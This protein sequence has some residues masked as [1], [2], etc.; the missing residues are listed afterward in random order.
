MGFIIRAGL[1]TA[2]GE[3]S[4]CCFTF[5]GHEGNGVEG[6]NRNA[7]AVC[8]TFVIYYY[9]HVVCTQSMLECLPRLGLANAPE[10]SSTRLS[11]LS[12]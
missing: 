12:S 10:N 6:N 7:A 11:E 5:R 1:S 3:Q 4:A 2:R 8:L 9:V